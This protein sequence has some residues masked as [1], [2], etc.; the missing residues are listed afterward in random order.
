MTLASAV[1]KGDQRGALQA[2]A[3]DLAGR[4]PDASN[5]DAPT[6]AK[7]LAQ[8]LADMKALPAP[9]GDPVG[10]ILDRRSRRTAEDHPPVGVPASGAAAADPP[11]TRKRR[12]AGDG[13]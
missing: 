8:T 12:V 10:H 1:S 13:S 9:E 4:L 2:I 11:R 7:Q 3:D 5:G 6:I